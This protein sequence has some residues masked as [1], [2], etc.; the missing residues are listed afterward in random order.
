MPEW[1]RWRVTNAPRRDQF[2]YRAG[3]KVQVVVEPQP[4]QDI[5]RCPLVLIATAE[6]A[7][8]ESVYELDD[9][10]PSRE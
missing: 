4:C 9:G 2:V 6:G 8:W 7:I 1:R 3:A 10:H 5:D